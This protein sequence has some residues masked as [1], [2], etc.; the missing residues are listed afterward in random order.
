HGQDLTT[1]LGKIL[2]LDV[3]HPST[4]KAYQIPSDNPFVGRT[5]ARPEIWAYGF[6]EPWRFSFDSRTGDL[7]VGDVGQD[8]FEEVSIVRKGENHGWNV[9]EGSVPFA[10]D[11]HRLDLKYVAPVLT[12]PRRQGVSVTGGYVYRGKLAP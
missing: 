3:D 5:N 11:G 6:R 7:W 8:R 4:G 9:Y 12:Y 2:R 10:V 1:F